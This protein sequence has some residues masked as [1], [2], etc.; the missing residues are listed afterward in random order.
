MRAEEKLRRVAHVSR[1]AAFVG[2]VVFT[3]RDVFT[4][5]K[6]SASVYGD[7]GADLMLSLRARYKFS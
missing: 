2:A 4:D 3:A 5:D 6:R 7:G 1:G